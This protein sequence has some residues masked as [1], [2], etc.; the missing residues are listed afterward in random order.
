MRETLNKSI[1]N[2]REIYR[3]IAVVEIDMPFGF[4]TWPIYTSIQ[5]SEYTGVCLNMAQL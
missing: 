2:L 3:A 5:I 1:C 4:V